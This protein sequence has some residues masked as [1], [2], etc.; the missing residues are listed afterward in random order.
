MDPDAA[1]GTSPFD[2]HVFVLAS[3]GDIQEG[4][5][6]E[7]SSLAG[8]Q[9]LGNL[10]VVYDANRISIED[11]TD[12][13]FTEDVAR[14]YEAYGWHVQEVD[15]TN[16]AQGHAVTEY[17]EDVEALYDAL[18]AAKAETGRP[19]LIKLRTVIGWPSPTKQNTGG[20]HGS[21]LGTDEVAG[22]KEGLGLDPTKTFDVD[23]ELLARARSIAERSAE[24]R[25]GWEAAF[26]A[27]IA[28]KL[29]SPGW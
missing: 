28:A 19:S 29:A 7:A 16:G 3:D 5:A 23:P 24:Y 4:V 15:W 20:I 26:Q 2:H 6:A 25:R 17:T 13:A 12:V 21:K 14:R 22:L 8:H 27:W 9:E 1:P 18:V 11:D 10:V